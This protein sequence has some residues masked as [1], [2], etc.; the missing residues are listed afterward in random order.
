MLAHHAEDLLLLLRGHATRQHGL[1]VRGD[2][3]DLQRQL[4]FSHAVDERVAG[5]YE[6]ETLVVAVVVVRLATTTA[7]GGLLPWSAASTR[8]AGRQALLQEDRHI[9]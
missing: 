3:D 2:V 4:L 9:V 6:C 8:A 5:Q 1:A 7:R